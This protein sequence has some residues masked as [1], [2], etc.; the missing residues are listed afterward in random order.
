MEQGERAAQNAEPCGGALASL[1]LGF[2]K[3]TMLNAGTSSEIVFA[4]EPTPAILVRA[5]FLAGVMG[6][7]GGFLPAIR[8]ARGSP[9]SGRRGGK[10]G[11]VEPTGS[12]G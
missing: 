9:V 7:V 5:I 6:V 4:F 8:A 10:T 12:T 2:V 11:P 1:A 3:I